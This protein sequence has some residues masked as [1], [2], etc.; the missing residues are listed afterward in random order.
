SNWIRNA[1][2]LA[3]GRDEVADH[4]LTR[5]ADRV[6]DRLGAAAAVGDHDDAVDAEQRRAA[7]LL[8]VD[9]ALDPPQ[10]GTQ[11][12]RAEN[13]EPARLNLLPEDREC[14]LADPFGELD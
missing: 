11:E 9:P 8:V 10:R 13:G 6:L 7:V 1:D 2:A 12:Q 3:D 4:S 5:D 14:H